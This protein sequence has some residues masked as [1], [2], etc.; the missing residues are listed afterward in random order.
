MLNLY[1][2]QKETAPSVLKGYRMFGHI[3]NN[4]IHQGEGRVKTSVQMSYSLSSPGVIFSHQGTTIYPEPTPTTDLSPHT[5]QFYRWD[6]LNCNRTDPITSFH[7]EPDCYWVKFGA[8][9]LNADCN[10]NRF[11]A[12]PVIYTSNIIDLLKAADVFSWKDKKRSEIPV[13]AS[14][15]NINIKY[16]NYFNSN[17]IKQMIN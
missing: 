17:N 16:I 1:S 4:S 8:I 10:L 11:T 6:V 2:R 7:I 12:R 9:S 13:T 5:L 14:S 3:V 15:N